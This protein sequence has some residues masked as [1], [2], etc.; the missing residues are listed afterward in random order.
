MSHDKERVESIETS[1]GPD[2][3][4]AVRRV[5][6]EVLEM[7]P[8]AIELDAD[9]V[10]DLGM[11]SMMALEILA[12]LEKRFKIRIAEENLPRMST[13]RKILEITQKYVNR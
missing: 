6:A 4:L 5:I 9:L 1:V 8:G 3:A 11:D 7:D 12:T 13:L 2:V 10:A